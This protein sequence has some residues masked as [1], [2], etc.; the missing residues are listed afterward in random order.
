MITNYLKIA[1]RHM[2]RHRGYAIINVLG[3]TLGITCCLFIFLWVRDEES[4][5]HYNAKDL[6]IVYET[7]KDDGQVWGTYTTPR[8]LIDSTHLG[9][10]MED[11]PKAVPEIQKLA[12]YRTGYELPWGFPESLKV[13]EKVLKADGSRAGKDFVKMFGL[14]LAAGDPATVLNDIHNIVLSRRVA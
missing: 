7:V 14:P 3:L 10:I 1:W 12:C 8:R 13:G 6:Y 5:D 9:Y 2:T 4:V 11:A